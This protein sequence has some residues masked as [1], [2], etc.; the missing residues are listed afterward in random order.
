M[1]VICISDT[2]GL[3]QRLAVPEGDILIHAGDVSQSGKK[4]EIRNFLS[5]FARQPHPYKIFIGGNHDFLMEKSPRT[6]KKLIPSNCIYLENTAVNI[7]GLRIWGSPITPYFFD[8]AFNRCRGKDIARYWDQIPDQLD[9]L[10]THGPPYGVLDITHDRRK[11]G[12]R[13]LQSKI[14]ETAPQYHIFGHIHEA[15]GTQM[16]GNTMCMNV[17]QL[18]Q[19]H[20]VSPDIKTL[21]LLPLSVPHA[22]NQETRH[23]YQHAG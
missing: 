21:E 14:L 11:V 1:K 15:S 16:L 5:W 10:I 22:F 3:H 17:S 8:W 7:N 9:I 23:T 12:C 19:R 2:H 18:D 13:A 20:N 4:S 6:F